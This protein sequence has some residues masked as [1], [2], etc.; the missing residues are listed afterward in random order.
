MFN[1]LKMSNGDKQGSSGSTESGYSAGGR[2]I[3]SNSVYDNIGVIEEPDVFYASRV[4]P[5]L[6]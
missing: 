6:L 5:T 3:R 4:R 2:L 1:P